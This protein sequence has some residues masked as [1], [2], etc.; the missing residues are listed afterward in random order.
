MSRSNKG[1]R[2]IVKDSRGGGST[3]MRPSS[4]TQPLA[5]LPYANN[6][7]SSNPLDNNQC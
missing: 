3:D 7:K 1:I 2:D 4:F 6:S 5:S